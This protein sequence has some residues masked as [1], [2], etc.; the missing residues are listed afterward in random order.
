[1]I[2]VDVACPLPGAVLVTLFKNNPHTHSEAGSMGAGLLF[3]EPIVVWS[4]LYPYHNGRHGGVSQ[5]APDR[6]VTT[7]GGWR[8]G[9]GGEITKILH[10]FIIMN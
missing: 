6:S 9:R 3:Q 2:H 1:M 4:H 7:G 10:F 5:L 8:G